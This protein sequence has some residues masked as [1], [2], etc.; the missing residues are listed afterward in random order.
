AANGRSSTRPLYK[1]WPAG[2][3]DKMG[4]SA[5][6][7]YAPPMN[8]ILSVLALVLASGPLAAQTPTIDWNGDAARRLLPIFD[9]TAPSTKRA[10]P[11][12]VAPEDSLSGMASLSCSGVVVRI[13]NDPDSRALL[14]SNGHCYDMLEPD[15]F[16]ANQPY[17]RSVSLFR[18]DN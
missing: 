11:R 6:I 5:R 9:G 18:R 2:D 17:Q 14:L 16:V 3:R 4:P 15:T 10:A 12:F 7:C 1:K 8:A 13:G